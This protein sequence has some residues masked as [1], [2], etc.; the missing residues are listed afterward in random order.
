MV[1]TIFLFM[2]L[3]MTGAA[4]IATGAT[5]PEHAISNLEIGTLILGVFLIL[6]AG[7]ILGRCS[8]SG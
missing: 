1:I 6:V 3:W 7:Y 8:K 5:G 2:V 4:L